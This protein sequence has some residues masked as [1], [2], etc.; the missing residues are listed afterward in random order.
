MPS[1]WPRSGMV[2]FDNNG[3]PASGALAYFFAGNTTTPITVYQDAAETTPHERPVEA[4]A[5]GRWPFVFVP[6]RTDYD[7]QATDENGTQLFYGRRIPNADPVEAA[8]EDVD[9]NDLLQTG[10][11]VWRPVGGVL[12]GRVRCNGRTLGNAASGATERANADTED[13]FVFLWNGLANAQAAV[14][15]SGRGASAAADYAANKTIAL[16]DLRFATVKGEAGM[17]NTAVT[18][19]AAVTIIHGTSETAGASVGA[20]THALTTAQLAAHTHGVGT[21]SNAADGAHQHTGTTD[22]EGAHTHSFSDTDSINPTAGGQAAIAPNAGQSPTAIQDTGAGVDVFQFTNYAD[23]DNIVVSISGT[24]G[25]GSSHVHTF[26]TGLNSA[27]THVL[28]GASGSSGSGD[29]HNNE[30]P[31]VLGTFYMVL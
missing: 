31:A 9:D 30:P 27:H 5:N 4:D 6:F 8:E 20:Q 29:A 10:D 13:L 7:V 21:Y 28:S 2:E 23:M 19:N 25:A 18:V 17:G 24:T 26:T 12:D 11:V 15:P 16:P 22:S 1:A 14:L 3:D